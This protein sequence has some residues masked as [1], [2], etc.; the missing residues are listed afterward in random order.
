MRRVRGGRWRIALLNYMIAVLSLVLVLARAQLDLSKGCQRRTPLCVLNR[1]FCST[2]SRKHGLLSTSTRLSLTPPSWPR[3]RPAARSRSAQADRTNSSS[4]TTCVATISSQWIVSMDAN[5]LCAGNFA[6][7]KRGPRVKRAHAP[8]NGSAMC[9][10][11]RCS[12]G[13]HENEDCAA[14]ITHQTTT[15]DICAA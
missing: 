5:P 6:C 1:R 14:R 3:Q 4:A 8:T 12:E 10:M 2:R 9:L 15:T 7:W 13:K 11:W